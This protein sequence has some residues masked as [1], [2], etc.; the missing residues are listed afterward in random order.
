MDLNNYAKYHVWAGDKIRA[1]VEKLSKDEFTKDLGD[2]FSHNT[3]HELCLHSLGA[4]KFCLALVDKIYPD[5][6]S[7]RYKDLM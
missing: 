2:Y 5:I 4:C 7:A 3:I 1:I 6:F